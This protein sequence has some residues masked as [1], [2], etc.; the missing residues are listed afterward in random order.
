VGRT[1]GYC[2]P[3]I[4]AGQTA[5]DGA[6]SP[7]PDAGERILDAAYGL[8]CSRGVNIVGIDEIIVTSGVARQT[9]YRRFR[10]KQD[11]VLAV[12][13][14]RE[15]LWTRGWL[16][17]EVERRASAP[18]ERLLAIF[19]VFDEWFRREDFEACSF[20]SVLLEM[21]PQHPAG[22]ASMRHL[23]NIRSMVRDLAEEAG[24][25]DPASFA[26]SW[27]ILMKGSI[28]AAAEGDLEAA[29]RARAMARQ[30]IDEYR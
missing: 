23:E 30:L 3:V 6:A 29:R 25:R 15:Q 27:H 9:L 22:K 20:I 28:V 5:V 26:H 14:R 1:I 21:G 24:L 10:S 17:A 11:L 4:E 7:T 18:D 16:Q 8:F 12:L 19:E 2:E 13:E